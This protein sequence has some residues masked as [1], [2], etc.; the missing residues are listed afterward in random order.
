MQR[1]QFITLVGGATAAW[2]FNA[3]AQSLPR[4]A[5]IGFLNNNS[6]ATI[7][8]VYGS[9]PLGLRE[10]GYIEGRDYVV[11]ERHAEGNAGRLQS[12]AE[13]LVQ[14]KP[15]LILAGTTPATVAARRATA[16]IPIVGLLL[17][18]PVGFGLVRS[19]NH[20]GTNVTGILIRVEGL[21]SKHLEIARDLVPAAMKI[22]A[23]ADTDN[24]SNAVQR[25]EVES[26]AARLGV[27]L[28]VL[29]VRTPD[30]IGAAFQ[31]FQREQV[32][33][34]IVFSGAPFNTARR[35]IAAYALVARL[36]TIF[37]D[38]ESVEAGGLISY[39]VSRSQTYR[40]AAYYVDKILKGAKT[41][42]LPVEFPNKVE[43]IINL[44][45]AKAIGLAIP[46]TLLAIAD[47]VIE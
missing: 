31:A 25:R 28:T 43:L 26:A 5:V 32:G 21:P 42:D 39:G 12:F 19:E 33:V 16:D 7:S 22:G 20:P 15:D 29:E 27:S 23:L 44:A 24:P 46:P 47:E 35:Q 6:K 1:R 17:T 3:R 38:R 14:L 11:E 40:R 8:P 34:V 36:P 41:A 30:E 13:E 18:D 9:F 37:T 10:L 2:P 45:A 4:R